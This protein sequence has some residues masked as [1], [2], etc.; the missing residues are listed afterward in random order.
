MNTQGFITVHGDSGFDYELSIGCNDDGYYFRCSC[1]AGQNAQLCKHRLRLLLGD[2][3]DIHHTNDDTLL[4]LN[5][6]RSLSVIKTVLT[7]KNEIEQEQDRLK[8]E[9]GKLKKKM[10]RILEQ[11]V[12]D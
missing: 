4:L 12:L 1:P 2:E 11:G 6:L 3:S 9:L 7:Q 10:G 5:K 8:K